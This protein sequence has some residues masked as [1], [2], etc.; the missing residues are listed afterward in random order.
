MCITDLLESYH[1]GW[2][3]TPFFADKINNLIGENK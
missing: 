3:F 2:Y 1:F